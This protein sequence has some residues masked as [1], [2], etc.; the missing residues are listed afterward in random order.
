MPHSSLPSLQSKTT[1]YIRHD[2]LPLRMA[3]IYSPVQLRRS[4]V[5]SASQRFRS[6]SPY[7]PC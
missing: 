1:G 5:V 7:L 6:I 2:E 3:K 4:T